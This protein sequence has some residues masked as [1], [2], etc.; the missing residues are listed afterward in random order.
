M[1]AEQKYREQT[2]DGGGGSGVL[3]KRKHC[4]SKEEIT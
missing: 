3:K 2:G 1:T 4:G